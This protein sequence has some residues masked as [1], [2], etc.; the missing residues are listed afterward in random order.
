MPTQIGKNWVE[1]EKTNK[2]QDIDDGW[3]LEVIVYH[4]KLLLN[5]TISLA[6]HD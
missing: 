4:G 5:A 1:D 2:L 6:D 3:N